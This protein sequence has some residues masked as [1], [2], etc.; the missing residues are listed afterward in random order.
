MMLVLNG[1]SETILVIHIFIVAIDIYT[2]FLFAFTHLVGNGLAVLV[3]DDLIEVFIRL[4]EL[5]QRVFEQFI[6]PPLVKVFIATRY[7]FAIFLYHLNFCYYSA[8]VAFLWKLLLTYC[9]FLRH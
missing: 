1:D 4:D 5:I 9:H 3:R 7:I 6:C 2:G 8:E